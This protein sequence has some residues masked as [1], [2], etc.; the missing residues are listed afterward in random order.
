MLFEDAKRFEVSCPRDRTSEFWVIVE[1][2]LGKGAAVDGCDDPN[3][4]C[5][6]SYPYWLERYPTHLT[7]SSHLIVNAANLPMREKPSD[8]ARTVT[9]LSYDVVRR[10]TVQPNP[11]PDGWTEVELLDGQRGFIRSER[12][13]RTTGYR[14]TFTR[15]SA[16][17]WF[18]ASFLAGD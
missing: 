9:Q 7:R 14:M 4:Q 10:V 12:L 16:G 15:L 2:L 18:L 5:R 3:D 8:A 17:T 6:V 1:D 11:P 13:Y